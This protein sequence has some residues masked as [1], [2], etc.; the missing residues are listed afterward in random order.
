MRFKRDDS[1]RYVFDKPLD[2]LFRI[3]RVDGDEVTTS[4][5]NARII[6][7]SPGGVKLNTELEIPKTEKKD[8]ELSV[9]FTLNEIAFE[10]TGEVVWKKEAAGFDYGLDLLISEEERESLV[11]EVKK[12]ANPE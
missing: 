7:I 11:E 6:D 12:F 10:V 9:S 4:E 8:I 2:A 3:E 1:F 5:G